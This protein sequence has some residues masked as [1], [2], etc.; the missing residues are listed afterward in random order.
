VVQGF[1]S[2]GK[3]A[4]LFLADK[5]AVLVAAINMRGMIVDENGLDVPSLTALK[6]EGRTL[7]DNPFGRKL[8]ADAGIDVPCEI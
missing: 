4:A 2:V 6:A 7:C 1:G 5:G 8:G 3:R